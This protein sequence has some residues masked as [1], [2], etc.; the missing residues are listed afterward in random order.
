MTSQIS[1]CHRGPSPTCSPIILTLGTIIIS[2]WIPHQI[3]TTQRQQSQPN[4][5]DYRPLS[6]D[7]SVRPFL[8]SPV[9]NTSA[10]FNAT[11]R[12]SHPDHHH[13]SHLLTSTTS[14][15]RPFNTQETTKEPHS[16]TTIVNK[17]NPAVTPAI[18]VTFINRSPCV[19]LSSLGFSTGHTDKHQIDSPLN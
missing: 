12:P 14:T 18:I 3:S 11:F 7:H 13:P 5:T 10:T 1:P 9:A 15:T 19:K 6:F 17:S 2:T 8:F 4:N 16:T